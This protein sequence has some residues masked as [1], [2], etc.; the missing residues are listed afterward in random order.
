MKQYLAGTLSPK[1]N[2]QIE[3]RLLE[4]EFYY[5]AVEGLQQVP[6]NQWQEQLQQTESRIANEFAIDKAPVKNRSIAIGIIGLFTA[7]ISTWYFTSSNNDPVDLSTGQVEVSSQP[8]VDNRTEEPVMDTLGQSRENPQDQQINVNEEA[9]EKAPADERPGGPVK[10]KPVQTNG[11]QSGTPANKNSETHITVGRVID[12]R[13]IPIVNATV[14]S[15]KITDTTDKS[16]YYALR[17][18]VGGTSIEVT[19]LATPYIVEIDSNQSWEIV[20]DIAHQKVIDY[21]PMNAA[22][23]FK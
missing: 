18:P 10:R 9:Q 12:T 7:L 14:T 13:G 19:H 20:L 3:D 21:Y 16:G 11:V 4:N 2:Y 6:V 1:E 17:V 8:S 5:E 22:N 23:R 15:G